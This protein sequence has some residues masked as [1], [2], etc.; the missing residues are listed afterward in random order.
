MPARFAVRCDER[1]WPTVRSLPSQKPQYA[2]RSD[3]SVIIPPKLT[4]GSLAP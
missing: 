1:T 2:I 3:L 4:N